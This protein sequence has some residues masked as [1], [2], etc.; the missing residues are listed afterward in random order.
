MVDVMVFY[1]V[2]RHVVGP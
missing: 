2:G 1:N